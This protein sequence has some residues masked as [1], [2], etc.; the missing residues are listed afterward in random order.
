MDY[1]QEYQEYSQTGM[2]RGQLITLKCVKYAVRVFIFGIIA[3][4]LWRVFF[5]GHIPKSMKT[6]TANDAL[7]EAYLAQGDELEMFTQHRDPVIM[8]GET[9]GYFWVCQAVFIPEA[10]QVQ[11][12][13]RYNNSTIDHIARDFSLEE[14]E[15]PSHEDNIVDVTLAIALNP[16]PADSSSVAREI[17]RLQPSGEPTEDATAMYNY[18]RYVFDNVDVDIASLINISVDFY[19]AGSVNYNRTPYSSIVIYEPVEEGDPLGINESVKLT[20]R[21]KRALAAFGESR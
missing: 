11:V 2:S 21:D 3:L 6:L 15:I 12:L 5:S 14:D 16:D 17:I 20:G 19:Y 7:Y 9:A 10:N 18:R 1:E 13:I 8:E 4:V